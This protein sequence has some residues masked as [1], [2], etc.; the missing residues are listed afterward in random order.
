MG[1]ILAFPDDA[2]RD[3]YE[4]RKKLAAILADDGATPG[5]IQYILS[6]LD[7]LDPQERYFRE[8]ARPYEL[9][10]DALIDLAKAFSEIYTLAHGAD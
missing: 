6:R 1:D 9:Q 5:R 10:A 8:G 4:I 3:W 7:C 2:E